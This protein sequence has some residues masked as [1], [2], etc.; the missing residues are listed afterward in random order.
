MRIFLLLCFCLTACGPVIFNPVVDTVL[1]TGTT[2]A[3]TLTEDR[4]FSEKTTDSL[5]KTRIRE[6]FFSKNH[7]LL[8]RVDIIVYRKIVLLSGLVK[9]ETEKKT[10]IQTAWQEK[11][12]LS[13]M[14]ALYIESETTDSYFRTRPNMLIKT[15]IKAAL[16]GADGIKSSNLFLSVRG[17]IVHMMGTVRSQKEKDAIADLVGKV[18]YV[19]RYRDYTV[20]EEKNDDSSLE[21]ERVNSGSELGTD[22]L[23]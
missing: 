14:D 12:V 2:V 3:R 10:L 4:K 5:I 16:L 6:R 13:V 11:D 18:P 22:N 23:S 21:N 8:S 1:T 19:R 17:R 15:Q 20:L 9:N 7:T